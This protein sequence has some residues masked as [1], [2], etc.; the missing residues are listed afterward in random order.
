MCISAEGQ[1]DFSIY[2]T[3]CQGAPMQLL[4][5]YIRKRSYEERNSLALRTPLPLK[6]QNPGVK[7]IKLLRNDGPNINLYFSVMSTV[8]VAESLRLGRWITYKELV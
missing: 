7:S 3:F 2:L 6:M 8:Y 1:A 4:P 5:V